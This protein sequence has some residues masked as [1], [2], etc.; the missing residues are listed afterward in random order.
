[1]EQEGK[2]AGPL[3]TLADMNQADLARALAVYLVE[4]QSE[5]KLHEDKLEVGERVDETLFAQADCNIRFFKDSLSTIQACLQT[6]YAELPKDQQQAQDAFVNQIRIVHRLPPGPVARKSTP[7]V[8][9]LWDVLTRFNVKPV[10]VAD[11]KILHEALHCCRVST[12]L[13]WT[14]LAEN[15]LVVS[16]DSFAPIIQGLHLACRRHEHVLWDLTVL[17]PPSG[18]V[19]AISVANA[20]LVWR[21]N[22]SDVK[23]VDTFDGFVGRRGVRKVYHESVAD[24]EVGYDE[25]FSELV[26]MPNLDDYRM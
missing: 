10:S 26:H 24:V 13:V 23:E 25:F 20:E 7:A 4:A 21:F 3:R 5:L 18:S 14:V 6:T 22:N 17:D 1:M 11:V 15:G 19:G 2:H 9:L 8:N 12:D 16:R